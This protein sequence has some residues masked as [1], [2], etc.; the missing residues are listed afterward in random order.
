[1][2]QTGNRAWTRMGTA[3]ADR[4]TNLNSAASDAIAHARPRH[5]PMFFGIVSEHLA[6][7]VVQ[8]R[9][10]GQRTHELRL[11]DVHFMIPLILTCSFPG[12]FSG[13]VQRKRRRHLALSGRDHALINWLVHRRGLA[14]IRALP[15]MILDCARRE[16]KVS[17][18]GVHSQADSRPFE[19][20]FSTI[21]SARST[22]YRSAPL[23]L[24]ASGF[25]SSPGSTPLAPWR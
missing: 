11:Y 6:T 3:F 12:H 25:S 22:P 8:H 14:C 16:S 7:D 21:I 4:P 20:R 18:S 13:L 15:V 23:Q 9:F 5:N 24:R 2:I 10:P 19:V 1:M 17:P